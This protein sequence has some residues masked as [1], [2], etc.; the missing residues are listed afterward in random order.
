MLSHQPR[1]VVQTRGPLVVR[2]TDL[3]RQFEAV[4]V[5]VS[6]PTDSEDVRHRFEPKAPP[7]ERRWLALEELSAA[8]VPI[9][10]CVTPTLPIAEPVAFVDRIA[11]LNPAVTVVQEF[12]DSRGRFGADTA[13]KAVRLRDDS[14]WGDDEYRQFV[15]ILRR[16]IAVHE[17]ESG[18]SPP[19]A[20]ERPQEYSGP[21]PLAEPSTGGNI[22]EG[23]GTDSAQAARPPGFIHGRRR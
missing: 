16:R 9:G 18:F 22:A 5:N 3:L 11:R 17:G 1:L 12:H 8:G 6:I 20:S 2:D 15:E 14:G 23:V 19:S 7:L 10:V 13:T 4:R 21:F